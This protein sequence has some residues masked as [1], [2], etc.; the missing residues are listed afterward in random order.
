MVVV[1]CL[2]FVFPS[3]FVAVQ[4]IQWKLAASLVLLGAFL[5]GWGMA[6]QSEWIAVMIIK[7]HRSLM[8][9]DENYKKFVLEI[10]LACET[11]LDSKF[12]S[13]V[14]S[15]E[16]VVPTAGMEAVS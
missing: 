10:N 5:C 2:Y 14:S 3:D 9:K 15:S 6:L 13:R 16:L 4:V 12:A 11:S 7:A 1:G 8:E